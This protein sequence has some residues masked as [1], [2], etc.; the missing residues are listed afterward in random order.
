MKYTEF[1]S[2]LRKLGYVMTLSGTNF[3]KDSGNYHYCW[4]FH[5]NDKE[6]LISYI[7]DEFN[8]VRQQFINGEVVKLHIKPVGNSGNWEYLS[9]NKCIDNIIYNGYGDIQSLREYR[10]NE[11]GI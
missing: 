10:L 1:L 6:V 11:L 8:K 7:I 3:D 4:R 5:L 2:M 9:Y